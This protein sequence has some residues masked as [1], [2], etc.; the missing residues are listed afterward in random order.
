MGAYWI[1]RWIGVK[2]VKLVLELGL[3]CLEKLSRIPRVGLIVLQ[4]WRRGEILFHPSYL[5]SDS[6]ERY[7]RILIPDYRVLDMKQD[8]GYYHYY[9]YAVP[10]LR[11]RKY[12]PLQPILFL[13]IPQPCLLWIRNC[14][15]IYR[16][17][18]GSIAWF[19]HFN[20]FIRKC[21]NTFSVN[22][23]TVSRGV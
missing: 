12:V 3:L 8:Q 16:N 14:K 2:V 1:D 5:W 19:Q 23:Q 22:Q 9:S 20:S 11:A 7:R 13:L 10:K 21:T 18:R 17:Q 6:L 15:L 4:I